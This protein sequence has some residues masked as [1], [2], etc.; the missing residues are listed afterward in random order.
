MS[1]LFQRRR[2]V[3][4]S[5][6]DIIGQNGNEVEHYGEEED[7]NDRTRTKDSNLTGDTREEVPTNRRNIQGGDE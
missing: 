5:R 3:K 4:I 7:N 1:V 6:I 2:E